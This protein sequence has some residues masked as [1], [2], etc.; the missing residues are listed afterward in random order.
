MVFLR[1]Y[2]IRDTAAGRGITLNRYDFMRRA[3]GLLQPERSW[4]LPDMQAP[5]LPASARAIP[6]AAPVS[7]Q[8]PRAVIKAVPVTEP[9]GQ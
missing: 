4:A 3:Q 2:I 6:G 5:Q 8:T 1:P 7:L 9:V